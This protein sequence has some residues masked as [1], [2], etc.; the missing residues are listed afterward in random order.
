[1]QP[2]SSVQSNTPSTRCAPNAAFKNQAPTVAFSAEK[3]QVTLPCLSGMASATCT[4]DLEPKIKLSANATD[5]DNEVLL[6][7]WS[8][9]GGRISGQ[10][11]NVTLDLTGVAP[12]S[13]TVTLEVDDGR[14]C[15]AFTSMTL[16]VV[17]CTDCKS[18]D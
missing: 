16:T 10:G 12:G 2:A 18:Q 4:P 5:P 15:I 7:T 17:A 14:G 1:M 11:A 3:L 9:T 8:T 6:Y 13:Y